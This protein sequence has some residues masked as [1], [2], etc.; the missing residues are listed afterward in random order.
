[1]T[2]WT[3]PTLNHLMSRHGLSIRVTGAQPFANGFWNTVLHLVTDHGDLVFK[4]YRPMPRDSLFPNLPASEAL[5]LQRLHGMTVAPDLIAFLPTE[6]VLIYRYLPGPE[7]QGDVIAAAQL[8][9]RQ[10][11]ADPA[12]FRTVPTQPAAILTEGDQILSRCTPDAI[13]RSLQTCRPVPQTIAPAPLSLI[14]T[15]PAPANLN[16]HGP[17]LRVIDWQCPASGDLAQDVSVLF[18]PAFLTLYNRPLLSPDHRAL[19]LQTLDIP[20]LTAR[21]PAVEPAY[22]WRLACYCAHRM[23]TTPDQSLAHR[24]RQAAL[25]Q[26]AHL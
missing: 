21:L 4:H 16:G 14:H 25:T 22:A 19:F 15:D 9:R 1:M 17:A 2:H 20:A 3:L 11:R 8:M 23:Q 18:S 6:D 5:A 10:S 13:T 26:A 7:W 24:Y 12:G